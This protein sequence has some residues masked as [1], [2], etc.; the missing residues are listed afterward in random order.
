AGD[1]SSA[2]AG[3]GIVRTKDL[4]TWQRLPDLKS[5]SPQQRNVVLHPRFVDGKY[6]LYTRPQDGFI[7]TGAGGGIGWALRDSIDNASIGGEW[8][9]VATVER[10]IKQVKSGDRAPSI[11]TDEGWLHIAH[12]GRHTAAALRY[13][14]YACLCH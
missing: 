6:A 2:T 13:V 11:G 9:G 4:R 3:A 5:R 12:G 14:I 8:L 7:D 10:A 1:T